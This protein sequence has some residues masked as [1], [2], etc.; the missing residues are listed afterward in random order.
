MRQGKKKLV[1][2]FVKNGKELGIRENN[3]ESYVV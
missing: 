3:W 1:Y 2:G